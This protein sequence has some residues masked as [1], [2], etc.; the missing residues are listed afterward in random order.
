MGSAASPSSVANS[1]PYATEAP[2]IAHRA[3]EFLLVLPVYLCIQKAAPNNSG[4][5]GVKPPRRPRSLRIVVEVRCQ[6]PLGLRCRHALPLG[7]VRDL[8]ARQPAD[9][10]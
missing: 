5:G 8:L 4:R 3:G 10:E 1:Q 7:V 2:P 9:H 6:P